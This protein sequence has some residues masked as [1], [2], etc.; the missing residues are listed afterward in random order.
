MIIKGKHWVVKSEPSAEKKPEVIKKAEKRVI[1][2]VPKETTVVEE[3]NELDELL[4]KL[5]KENK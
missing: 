2:E 1:K 3:K 4:S 5:D